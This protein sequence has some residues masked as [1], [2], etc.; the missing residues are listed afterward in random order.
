[1]SAREK[2]IQGVRA[3]CRAA[4]GLGQGAVIVADQNGLRPALPYLVIEVV[5]SGVQ[6]GTDE[7][8]RD[9]G[10]TYGA[11][12]EWVRGHRRATV[13]VSGYGTDAPELLEQ[14]RLCLESPAVRDPVETLYSISLARVVTVQDLTTLRQTAYEVAA[15][16]DLEVTY[17]LDTVPVASPEA[18]S[19]VLG[20]TLDRTPNPPADLTFGTT[21]V[22][23]TLWDGSTE[24][25]DGGETSWDDG[26]IL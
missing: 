12:R 15:M 13:Q 16:M 10:G 11:M 1:M 6:V 8:M 21:L 7:L 4:T 3:F 25:W 24:L 26:T 17:R 9:L 18:A 22:Q 5:T 19:I 20:V 2:V 14:V 23:H